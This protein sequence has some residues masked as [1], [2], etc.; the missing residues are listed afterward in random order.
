MLCTMN[1][2]SIILRTCR[3]T[4]SHAD[5]IFKLFI[6]NCIYCTRKL[7][8][9]EGL[10]GKVAFFKLSSF[11]HLR[12]LWNAFWAAKHIRKEGSPTEPSRPSFQGNILTYS[13]ILSHG[14]QWESVYTVL[15]PQTV[16]IPHQMKSLGNCHMYFSDLLF[17]HIQGTLTI[18]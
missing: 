11:S 18:M 1:W 3:P 12:M 8:V 15:Q 17:K 9:S 2:E 16:S 13:A 5:C 14:V 7:R 6:N 4:C 10:Q